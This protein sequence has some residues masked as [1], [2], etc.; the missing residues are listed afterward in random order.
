MQ[1]LGMSVRG[2]THPN[3]YWVE[4]FLC[5]DYNC[6]QDIYTGVQIDRNKKKRYNLQ[7]QNNITRSWY[8]A[9]NKELQNTELGGRNRQICI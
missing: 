1:N 7:L 8:I 5:F 6:C 4:G 9:Q 3:N 2:K